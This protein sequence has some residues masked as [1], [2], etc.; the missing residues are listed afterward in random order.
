MLCLIPKCGQA[1]HPDRI[2]NVTCPV[3]HADLA[4]Q[5][6]GNSASQ[7][8]WSGPYPPWVKLRFEAAPPHGGALAASISA[9]EHVTRGIRRF[10]RS[11]STGHSLVR[12]NDN[13]E[14]LAAVRKQ[15]MDRPGLVLPREGCLRR[16][17]GWGGEGSN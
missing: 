17:N 14:R 5:P 9:T 10:S 2:G 4:S 1:F 13:T 11:H 3:C 7:L 12:L 15:L 16:G 6:A 8:P